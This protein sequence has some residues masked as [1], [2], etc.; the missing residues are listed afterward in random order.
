MSPVHETETIAGLSSRG[1]KNYIGAREAGESITD[2]ETDQR[3]ITAGS[4]TILEQ[5]G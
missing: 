2:S 3:F 5:K 1:N 4:M